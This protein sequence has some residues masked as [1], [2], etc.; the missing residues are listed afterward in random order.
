VIDETTSCRLGVVRSPLPPFEARTAWLIGAQSFNAAS[1]INKKPGSAIA[2]GPGHAAA[3]GRVR[4][5]RLFRQGAILDPA[6]VAV[7][8]NVVFKINRE[9]LDL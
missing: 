3:M 5:P 1:R 7:G 2:N 8:Q 4:A 6:D 9:D